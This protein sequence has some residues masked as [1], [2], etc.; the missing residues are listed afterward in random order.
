MRF[1]TIFVIVLMLI[2]CIK[3]MDAP[4]QKKVSEAQ[5]MDGQYQKELDEIKKSLKGDIKIKL[6]RESKG[7]YS[8][9]V[10]GKDAQEVLKANDAI[11]K[12]LSD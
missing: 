6:K 8:W 11:R 4:S 9:E 3:G 2:S 7:G 10:T 12:K 5:G 1:F